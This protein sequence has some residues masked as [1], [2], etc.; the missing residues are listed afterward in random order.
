[1]HGVG[2]QVWKNFIKRQNDW[3]T[4][5]CL[6]SQLFSETSGNKTK[7]KYV[8]NNRTKYERKDRKHCKLCFNNLE[9]DTRETKQGSCWKHGHGCDQ[10]PDTCYNYYSVNDRRIHTLLVIVIED[11]LKSNS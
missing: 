5:W 8:F 7:T 1:M 4:K 6:T 10:N 11:N 3:L 9:I 2:T